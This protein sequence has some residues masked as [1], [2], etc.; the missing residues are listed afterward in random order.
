MC[1]ILY[2][3]KEATLTNTLIENLSDSTII[4]KVKLKRSWELRQKKSRRMTRSIYEYKCTWKIEITII[5]QRINCSA[6]HWKFDSYR[7]LKKLYTSIKNLFKSYY[8]YEYFISKIIQRYLTCLH[9][10]F[11]SFDDLYYLIHPNVQ[12]LKS[13]GINL[14]YQQDTIDQYSWLFNS[15][16]ISKVNL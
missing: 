16:E 12:Q 8:M 15:H 7:S 9:M 14:K 3:D 10:F 6:L 4:I 1:I 5:N 13:V 11:N 2:I